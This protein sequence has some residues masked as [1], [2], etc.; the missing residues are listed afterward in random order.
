MKAVRLYLIV[1]PLLALLAT[2]CEEDVVAV[3]NAEYP[4]SMYGVLNPLADTQFVRVFEVDATLVPGEERPLDARFVS[5]DLQ[6]GEERV[7]R[8]S[9]IA[10][11]DGTVG[12]VFYSPFRVEWEHAYR[13]TISGSEGRESYVEVEVPLRSNLIVDAPDTTSR[14]LLPAHIEGQPEN[15]FNSEVEVRVKYVI[16]TDPAGNPF[17][18]NLR[19]PIPFDDGLRRTAT[20][21]RVE[22]DLDEAYVDVAGEVLRDFRYQA[23]YG[24]A[25]QLISFSAVV[26]NEEWAPPG[27]VFDPNVLI[28]PGAFSNVQNGFGFVAAGYT[29]QRSW[30]LPFE[31]VRKSN[32]VPNQPG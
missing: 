28:Q 14:V 10:I 29:L 7:W 1:L 23:R 22:V 5:R 13:L 19:W 11:S 8:D 21:W 26:G 4:Y 24:I 30:T 3:L 25:L 6:T 15:V 17:Y 18:E 20:G 9:L 16:G 31:V 2:G 12:H 27:G 32:F